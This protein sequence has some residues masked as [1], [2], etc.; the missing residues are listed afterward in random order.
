MKHFHF[1]VILLSFL[2]PVPLLHAQETDQVWD[3]QADTADTEP[4]YVYLLNSDVVYFDQYLNPDAQMLMGN[5]ILRHDSM[6]MYCDSALFYQEKNSFEAY[7]NV[8]I[9][10]GDTLFLFGDSVFYDGNTRLARVRSNV[11]L[12]N[13]SM[14]LLTDSLNFDRNT[15]LGW[16]FD[17]GTLLDNESTLISE[18]GQFDT[19]TKLSTFTDGVTLESPDYLLST[20]TLHYNTDTHTALF[21]SPST[22]DSGDKIIETRHGRFNTD[23]RSA[24]LLDRSVLRQQN[25]EMRMTADSIIYDE[26]SQQIRGY[27]DVVVND[28]KDKIDINGEYAFFSQCNDSAVVTGRALLTEYSAG[29]SLFVHADTFRL[30][31]FYDETG[32]TVLFRHVRAFRR[33]MAYR[34]DMQMMADSMQF[35]TKDSTLTLFRDPIIW[36]NNQQVLGEKITIY[37]N[38]STIDHA[39]VRGQALYIQRIDT[40]HSN[41]VT[42]REMKAWFSAGEL[43]DAEVTGNV[44]AIFYPVDDDSTMIG[45]NTTESS[46]LSIHFVERAVDRISVSRR[47]SGVM[48][49]MDQIEEKKMYLE[50]YNWFE[51]LRPRNRYDIFH[52]REKK[53]S[54]QLKK[55]NS[56][57]EVP[58]PT[59]NLNNKQ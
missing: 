5:V 19:G 50:N 36:N 27:G 54:E 26:D 48:Y 42:G 39:H 13:T 55:S 32:D 37:L 44:L 25:N 15:G 28:Y 49:P 10:Q 58:L 38:D 24:V 16:F 7:H 51:R 4:D 33:V 12:E 6:Y 21:N 45:M 34:T 47:S 35:S 14:I 9:E 2:L 31:T 43:T 56:S 53:A 23:R 30:K 40:V 52:W 29:D 1:A 18:Y 46:N 17:G 22:I 59:L 3:E 20:D 57:K 11:R 41:Q 8:R